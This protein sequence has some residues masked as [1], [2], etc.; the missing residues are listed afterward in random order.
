[1]WKNYI[2]WQR[3]T[4][5]LFSVGADSGYSGAENKFREKYPDRMLP[6]GIAEQ[7]QVGVA[8]GLA[9]CGKI[10]YISGFGRF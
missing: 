5:A 6:V 7:D 1:M 4:S 8:A 3:R 2:A 9:L 10:P